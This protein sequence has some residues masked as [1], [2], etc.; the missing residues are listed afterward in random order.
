[1]NHSRI[2]DRIIGEGKDADVDRTIA[3][4]VLH[5]VT[6][7]K[8][9]IPEH[10][11]VTEC[12]RRLEQ[13]GLL[14]QSVFQSE[15]EDAQKDLVH[16]LETEETEQ[17]NIVHRIIENRGKVS[18][19]GLHDLFIRF[20]I[21]SG[22]HGQDEEEVSLI[23]RETKAAL[24]S[25][26]SEEA[27]ME[28]VM[29]DASNLLDQL[30][31]T[32]RVVWGIRVF[33]R[34]LGKGGAGIE[35][36]CS[37]FEKEMEELQPRVMQ[38]MDRYHTQLE[39]FK[40][41][42][43]YRKQLIESGR[44]AEA[45]VER[46]SQEQYHVA[47]LEELYKRLGGECS[48]V[49]ASI[50][51]VV[52]DF[53][54]HIA[55]IQ[56]KIAS[57]ASSPSPGADAG[58]VGGL[59]QE[60]AFRMFGELGD[61]W[62]KVDRDGH[63]VLQIVSRLMDALTRFDRSSMPF[64]PSALEEA[65]SIKES[66]DQEG[67]EGGDG[68]SKEA[69]DLA[70]ITSIG[71]DSSRIILNGYDAVAIATESG[72][73]LE[74]STEVAV[75][76]NG[77]FFLFAN[78]TNALYFINRC[79]E[80]LASVMEHALDAPELIRLLRLEDLMPPDAVLREFERQQIGKEIFGSDSLGL[81]EWIM[82][83]SAGRNVGEYEVE[84]PRPVMVDMGTE[85]PLHFVEKHIEPKYRF[86]EWD[87]RRQAL[88]MADLRTKRTKSSQTHKSHFRRED[89]TQAYLPKAAST[90]TAKDRGTNPKKKVQYIKGLRGSSSSSSSKTESGVHVVELTIDFDW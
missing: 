69:A 42:L 81:S 28:I 68:S 51:P 6:K 40:T 53:R 75:E 9:K 34:E 4:F 80:V 76:H 46:I 32:A 87:L 63:S 19:E 2:L 17:T 10:E 35:N 78:D 39:H 13:P 37:E 5:V 16:R 89:E 25:V 84:K 49:S 22:K 44:I 27:I 58:G 57:S 7:N 82:Q 30:R 59:S 55:M 41:I 79:D 29:L 77:M 26:L 3:A 70:R 67:K 38:K 56:S 36:I 48:R 54:S 74:G 62:S 11:L 43:K 61:L 18:A 33:N 45:D 52:S 47:Q 83:Q 23:V 24:E 31:R 20:L 14:L 65:Y 71:A 12:I 72:M 73:L 21:V 1:M 85:T 50:G 90:Q 64:Q 60:D 66:E 88:Q 15:K 8:P 86:S